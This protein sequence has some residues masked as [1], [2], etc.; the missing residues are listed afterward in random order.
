MEFRKATNDD[1]CNVA[2]LYKQFFGLHNVFTKPIEN[3]VS[4][5]EEQVTKSELF[6]AEI[7]KKLFCAVFLVNKGGNE[8]K[9]HKLR[10]FAFESDSIGLEMLNWLEKIVMERSTTAKI[11]VTIAD[12]EKGFEMYKRA[13]FILEGSLSNHY[14][15]GEITFV[16]GKSY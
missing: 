2:Q 15:H 6:V 12:G 13:G 7:D 4:Y 14:R 11:E 16:L 10:H 9:L 5:L 8:H 1:F 3:I